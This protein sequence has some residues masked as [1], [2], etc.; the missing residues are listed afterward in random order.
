MRE[1]RTRA[2]HLAAAYR[3]T[4]DERYAQTAAALLEGFFL[5]EKTK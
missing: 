3:L 1:C 4:G 5:D 2:A